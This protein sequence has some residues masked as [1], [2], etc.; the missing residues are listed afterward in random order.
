MHSIKQLLRS[1]INTLY[2]AVNYTPSLSPSK[3]LKWGDYTCSDAGA[4][5]KQ[6][7]LK[8]NEVASAIVKALSSSDFTFTATG[9]YINVS[10]TKKYLQELTLNFPNQNYKSLDEYIIVDYSSPNI[11]K[12]L[13]IGHL[14]STI[15]GESI[16]R[17]LRFCGAQV[18][19]VNHLG[20]SGA[21]FGAS[22]AHIKETG[23]MANN[24]EELQALYKEAKALL[25]EKNCKDETKLAFHVKAQQE[26]L[27]LQNGD[28]ESKE[29]WTK[30]RNISLDACNVIYQRL[31]VNIPIVGESFYIPLIPGMLKELENKA[32]LS[33]DNGAKCIFVPDHP[34]QPLLLEKSSSG[35]GY[36]STDMAA[37]RYRFIE[38]RADKVLYVV[39]QGQSSHFQVLFKAAEMACYCK[40][41]QA[42]H[43]AFGVVL[44]PDGKR[45]KTRSGSSVGLLDLL[46]EARQRA[47][48]IY[49][50]KNPNTLMSDT[51]VD[52]LAEKIGIASLKYADLHNNRL[53]DYTF[54]FDR[55]L[56]YK[57]HTGVYL[58]YARARLCS[59]LA[60]SSVQPE[61]VILQHPTEFLLVR[62]L[63]KFSE[64]L[65]ASAETYQPHLLCDYL[66]ELAN[67]T[68]DFHRDCR[69]L[70]DPC[71]GQRLTLIKIVADNMKLVMNLLGIDAPNKI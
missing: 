58:L 33:L 70:G 64:V 15:I 24:L 51:E 2:P 5:A 56:D 7:K 21:N 46:D 17:I 3:N 29:I 25:P 4:I 49:L 63:A 12:N 9:S 22:F 55:M 37:I 69:V 13:H 59:I 52:L 32:L 6:L 67:V 66:Y 68:S 65:H 38:K 20:D 27:L 57:G 16:C 39:D 50:E 41:G 54:S 30:W 28:K 62:L 71:E 60:K 35:Y 43:I 34:K 23:K 18:E 14:R 11:L 44:G 1:T 40:T 8:P 31:D 19:G 61:P 53:K 36:D 10:F 48:K 42:H 47:K 26:A 45:F